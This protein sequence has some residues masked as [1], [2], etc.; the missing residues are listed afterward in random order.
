MPGFVFLALFLANASVWHSP[1]VGLLLAVF[2]LLFFGAQVGRFFSPDDAPELRWWLG[3][4]MLLS[5]VSLLGAAAYY[6]HSYPAWVAWTLGLLIAP[7]GYILQKK[8]RADAGKHDLWHEAPHRLPPWVLGTASIALLALAYTFR[9]LVSSATTIAV[10][11]PWSVVPDAVFAGM[12]VAAACLAALWSRGRER[13]LSTMLASVALFAFLSVNWAV[14]PIGAGFDPFI[15][16]ATER[17]IADAGTITPKPFYYVGQYALVLFLHHGFSIPVEAADRYLLPL[18]AALLLPFAWISASLHAAKKES[19]FAPAAFFALFLLPLGLFATTTPQGLANLWILLLI[20]AA[21]P[22]LSGNERPHPGLLVLPTL[23]TLAIHPLA[24]IPALLWC[25]YLLTDK[26]L[27]PKKL[28]KIGNAA[29]L[30]AIIVGAL[31]LP[32]AFVAF[33]WKNGL[34]AVHTTGAWDRLWS[35]IPTLPSIGYPYRTWLDFAVTIG[36]L[37]GIA[38]IGLALYGWPKAP[39]HLRAACVTFF[40]ILLGN[41]L[42]LG[43]VFD[44]SFLI[45]YERLNY[46]ARLP[47]LMLFALAPLAAYGVIRKREWLQRAPKPVQLFAMALAAAVIP[48]LW[49]AAYPRDDAYQKGHGYNVSAADVDAVKAIEEYAHR[50]GEFHPYT[51]LANQSVSAAAL[52]GIGFRYYGDQFFYPI[53][54][55]GDLYALFLKMNAEPTRETAQEALN[56]VLDRCAASMECEYGKL[57]DVYYVVDSYWWDSKNI[58]KKAKVNANNWFSVQDGAVHVFQYRFE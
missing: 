55:G 58:I 35:L 9:T 30:T 26:S 8:S 27:V 2:A 3:A 29:R 44:F 32:T 57:R 16:Q 42:L 10:A 56:F 1:T 47:P 28:A 49:Y 18:L 11:S 45:E 39:V 53:P 48:A 4:W 7:V 40:L 21:V 24:G 13:M 37:T 19:R 54:T 12:A 38:L 43:T 41:Y 5:G 52:T 6:I 46:A 20:L 34:A 22:F 50:G 25:A 33:A 36:W 31:L 14:F 15:H 51:T 17:Y 23:A